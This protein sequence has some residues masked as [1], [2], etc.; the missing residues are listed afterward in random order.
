M[1]TLI[2]TIAHAW[3]LSPA[4]Y[5]HLRILVSLLLAPVLGVLYVVIFD[6]YKFIKKP[7]FIRAPRLQPHR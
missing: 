3:D 4:Q 1:E 5:W 2:K 6:G 7:K